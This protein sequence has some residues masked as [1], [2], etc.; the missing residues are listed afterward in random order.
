MIIVVY[1]EDNFAGPSCSK[2]CKLKELVS[3][4]NVICS[5]K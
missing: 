3:G 4:Q 2:H 5:S 1:C